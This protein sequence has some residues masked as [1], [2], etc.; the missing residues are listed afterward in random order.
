MQPNVLRP[1][2]VFNVT[3]IKQNENDTSTI[4]P[5]IEEAS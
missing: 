2:V 3:I 4:D 1:R 5:W